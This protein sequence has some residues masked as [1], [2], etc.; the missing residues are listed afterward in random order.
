MST[1]IEIGEKERVRC[2]NDGFGLVDV[3]PVQAAVVTPEIIES[4]NFVTWNS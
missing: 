3:V 2:E 1:I 4:L